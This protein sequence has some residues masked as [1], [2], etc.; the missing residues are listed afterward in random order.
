MVLQLTV[1]CDVGEMSDVHLNEFCK[2]R[3]RFTIIDLIRQ[4]N[5]CNW[6]IE[7]LQFFR[8][9]CSSHIN[10]AYFFI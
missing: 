8:I 10:G 6:D 7:I 5:R 3:S 9:L 2:A 1:T 4:L